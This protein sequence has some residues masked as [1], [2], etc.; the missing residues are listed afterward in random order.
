MN[1]NELFLDLMSASARLQSAWA[2]LK[3][4]GDIE[5]AQLVYQANTRIVDVIAKLCKQYS[6]EHAEEAVS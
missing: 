2:T 6:I 4:A 5:A 1:G 3:A